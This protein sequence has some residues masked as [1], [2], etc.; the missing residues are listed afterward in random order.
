MVVKETIIHQSSNEV[1]IINN[2][3]PYGLHQCKN[4]IKYTSSRL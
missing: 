3:Q 1:D 2:W 4:P